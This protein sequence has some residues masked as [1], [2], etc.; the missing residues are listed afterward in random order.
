LT[1]HVELPRFIRSGIAASAIGHLSV[2]AMVL[3]LAEVHP[4]S[5]V[6][7]E[8]I[9]VDIVS[10]S[11]APPPPKIEETP[12]TPKVPDSFDLSEKSAP[13]A[14]PPPQAAAEPAQAAAEPAQAAASPAQPAVPPEQA[15]A[16][17]KQPAAP[18]AQP[19]QSQTAPSPSPS[20]S[21]QAMVP[22]PPSLPSPSAVPAVIPQEPDVSIKYHVLL[23]LPNDH[24]GGFDAPAYKTA[25][26]DDSHIAAFRRHLKTCSILP[27]SV[28]P[29]DGIKI[30]LRINMTPDGRLASEPILVE[31]SAS[32][33]GPA[34]MQ[35]AIHAL[36][37]CQPYAML[38]AD[39]YG[40]WKVL[41]VSFTP[42]D[43]TGGN[44]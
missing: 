3:I 10:P 34:L 2:L 40:E 31:A 18:P 23:G 8:P 16:Q 24:V 37:A 21:Q 7:A 22:S 13:A 11:E 35:S 41:D 4:F 25:D 43:F 33:K 39:R 5:S 15:A 38:P 26:V 12:P 27:K 30:M 32:A 6:T 19:A 44:G 28:A 17:S 14:Q 20:P 36:Q 9:T 29:S 1:N 42:Q